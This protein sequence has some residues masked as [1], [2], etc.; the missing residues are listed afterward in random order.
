MTRQ[1]LRPGRW[2]VVVLGILFVGTAAW[3][4]TARERAEPVGEVKTVRPVSVEVVS[5]R[6]GG[7]DRVCT[8]PGTVEPFESADL[9]AKVSGYLAEQEIERDGEKLLKDGQPVRV[10]IGTPVKAGDVLARISVP[11]Y[12]KQVEQDKADVSRAEVKVEQVTAAVTT[13]EADLGAA[14]AAIALARAEVKSKTSYREY[15][16]KQRNR[17]R[18]LAAEQAID[19][20]LVDEQEDQFQAA[21]AAELAASESVN[22][23]KQKEAAAAS[24]VKQAQA[25][26]KYAAAEVAVARARLEKS[27][28]LLGYTVIRSPYTGV[29][30]RRSFHVGDFVKAADAGERIPVLAVERTDVMRVVVHVPDRDVPF[31]RPGNPAAVRIDALPGE[32]FKTAGG[33]R[34]EVARSA[35]A[36]DRATR[37]MRTEVDVPNPDGKLR[38]GMYGRVTLTLRAGAA[39][40]VRIPS[41]ALVGKAEGGK[42]T[43]RV[44]RDD[45]AQVVPVEYG[46]DTGA[47]VEIVSGLTPAD[48]VVVKASGPVENG[49]PV[50]IA[51]R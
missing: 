35:T 17:L 6:A 4:A 32:V 11:E 39:S 37:L 7:I 48:R 8:Q 9:Y 14:T 23:A 10:D 26:L 22:A 12:E 42:A 46:T 47:E 28:V 1:S 50:S 34:V 44:V 25:D 16:E 43:V 15:R 40:A 30:T 51:R 19:R 24:R 33:N 49:T 2:S 18:E 3:Y 21:V 13:A 36:E 5:P 20:K 38:R 41:A 29:V 45:T 31:V 27:R